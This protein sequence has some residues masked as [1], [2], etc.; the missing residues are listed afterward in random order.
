MFIAKLEQEIKILRRYKSKL[1]QW[2]GDKN[3]MEYYTLLQMARSKR[4]LLGK[5]ITRLENLLEGG[6]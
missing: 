4:V 6:K 3:S 2:E 1:R 5:L